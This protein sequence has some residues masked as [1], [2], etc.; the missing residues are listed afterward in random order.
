MFSWAA[1]AKA[2]EIWKTLG[3]D[4]RPAPATELVTGLQTG[5]FEVFSTP[6]QVA[7]ITRYYEYAKFMTDLKWQL[8]LGAT[9]IKKETW[10]RIP[11]DLRPQLLQAAR[12]GGTKLQQDIRSSEPRDV[13]AMMK[14]GLTVVPVDAK[15]TDLWRRM[16]ES[17]YPQVR[18]GVVPADAFDEALRLRDE[19]R[20]QH[21]AAKK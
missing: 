5:L 1:D 13:A 9:V 11:A 17:S 15:A 21:G 7:V 14:V 3:F 19:Y 12:E 16:A 20:A 6:P 18:G 4:P 10:E 8:L 2:V